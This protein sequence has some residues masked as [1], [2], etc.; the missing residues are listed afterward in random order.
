M[1]ETKMRLVDWLDDLCVRFIINLPNEELQSVERICFQIEE[2]QWFYEDFIRPL[3]PSL[4]SMN[5]KKFCLLIFRHCPLLSAFSEHHHTQAYQEFL[6]YKTRVPVRGAIMLNEDMTQAVLVKGWKKG[7]KWSFPRGKINKDEKDLDC[8]VRE[9]Y[10]ETGFELREAGL[11]GEEENMKHIEVSMRE[12]HMR[13]YVFRGVP[14][15]THFEPRT[16]KEISKISWYKLGHLPTLKRNRAQQGN[17]EDLLKDNMF[18]M[19]AP[20]LQPLKN[21]I[22]LQRKLDRQKAAVNAHPAP[23]VPAGETDVWETEQDEG[24]GELTADEATLPCIEPADSNFAELVARLGRGHRSSDALPEVSTEPAMPQIA[25]PAEE[26]KRML[27]VNAGFPLQTPVEAPAT[28]VDQQPNPLLA[29]LHGNKAS[30]APAPR[31]PF[32]QILAPPSQPQSPPHHHPRPPHLANMPPPSSFPFQPQQTL[33]FRGPAYP[34]GSPSPNGPPVPIPQRF[35][36]PP[37]R[38]QN[39]VFPTHTPNIQQAFSQEVPRPY[40]RTGDPQFAQPPRFPDLH[41]SAIPPASKLPPPKL[42]AHTLGLLNTFKANE[43]PASQP[44]NPHSQTAQSPQATPKVQ[45][46]P[47]LQRGFE[48][49]PS[50]QAASANPY[51]PSPPPFKSPPPSANFQPV[52]PKPRSAHQDTLLNL[53]RSPSI[54]APT[55]PPPP[56]KPGAE[57]VELSAHPTPGHAKLYLAQAAGPPRPDLSNKPNLLEAFGQAPRKPSL[58]S[59]TV[60]GP[61]NAPD[62]ETVKKNTHLGEVNG[63]DHR[64]VSPASR[65]GGGAGS[66]VEDKVMIPTHILQRE[67]TPGSKKT[68]PTTVQPDINPLAMKDRN[69][70]DTP[71]AKV[72]QPQILKRPQQQ[73]SAPSPSLGPALANQ[74]RRTVAPAPAQFPTVPGAQPGFDRRDTL[75]GDQKKV[76]LDLFAKPPQPAK[77]P[78]PLSKF[79]LPPSKSPIPPAK[80]PQPPKSANENDGFKSPKT[81]MSGVISPVSP[82]PEK[83]S[84]QGSPAGLN[85]RS[86]IS[87]LGEGM[88]LPNSITLQT[89][90]PLAPTSQPTTGSAVEGGLKNGLGSGEES[91][92]C[93]GAGKFGGVG[94][95]KG[96][97][98][99]GE[100]KSPV[101]K[102]FLLGFLEGVAKR[103]R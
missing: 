54:P 48:S 64:D 39:P 17:G 96:S 59:A 98:G 92:G 47:A 15:D 56:S 79:P 57:L 85:S 72:F 93:T 73:S 20:F 30:D 35:I 83:G 36:P 28:V 12:Q 16:R 101:D 43:K 34:H 41:G 45:Q 7:A 60:S 10:E 69:A 81:L 71:Q 87:S 42:T 38:V 52:Q 67:N 49:F 99:A 84:L 51:V 37:P 31:T 19:V 8:A 40:H 29:M 1:T 97:G 86:R 9:V 90:L 65:R 74:F 70:G 50:P 32:D 25:D 26:L 13:L 61:L 66:G 21:W 89:Q 22:R 11:V 103:G 23:P 53:F 68:S 3:D 102:T 78:V 27:N 91:A 14:M 2:A 75:P 18:Y 88:G 80:S 62:F 58:T 33:P 76:L 63:H 6:A 4:P 95:L 82:L 100:G 5:L 94:A 44:A 77:P 55:P 24:V 46:P